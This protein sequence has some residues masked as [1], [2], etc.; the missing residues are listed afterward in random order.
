MKKTNKPAKTK[1]KAIKFAK[2]KQQKTSAEAQ[3][4]KTEQKT[5]RTVQER[6]AWL[7]IASLLFVLFSLGYLF[8]ALILLMLPSLGIAFGLDPYIGAA[9]VALSSVV[10]F[11]AALG[12]WKAKLY[13]AIAGA[14]FMALNL[15]SGVPN[16]ATKPSP[17]LFIGVIVEALI[18]ALIFANWKKFK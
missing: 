5:E 9:I 4:Q 6:N 14:V 17:G 16:L 13:G 8:F 12:I 18:L 10:C 11:V 3:E 15:I 7:I 2:Q 1:A